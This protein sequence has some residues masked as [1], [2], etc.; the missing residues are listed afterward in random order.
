MSGNI[1]LEWIGATPRELQAEQR[2]IRVVNK[3]IRNTLNEAITLLTWH[4]GNF[5]APVD[6]RREIVGR[7]EQLAAEISHLGRRS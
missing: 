6:G 4:I 2:S 7:L 5:E 3:L 1:F